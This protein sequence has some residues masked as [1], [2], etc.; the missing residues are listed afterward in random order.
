MKFKGNISRS[1]FPGTDSIAFK[2]DDMLVARLDMA[3]KNLFRD[4]FALV[5]HDKDSNP[6]L[7]TISLKGFLVKDYLIKSP[8]ISWICKGAKWNDFVQRKKVLTTDSGVYELHQ[9]KEK[10]QVYK[11]DAWIGTVKKVYEGIFD[12]GEYEASFDPGDAP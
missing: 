10:L 2:V 5:I 11:K 9:E 12:A 6:V 3:S 8:T 1:F 4:S 7:V